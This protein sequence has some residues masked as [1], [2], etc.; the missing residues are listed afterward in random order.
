M[1]R[2]YILVMILFMFLI[3]C[4]DYKKGESHVNINKD[5]QTIFEN[6]HHLFNDVGKV[7]EEPEIFNVNFSFRPDKKWIDTISVQGERF[8]FLKNTNHAHE[9]TG[10]LIFDN[11]T[12]KDIPYTLIALQG[13][14]IANIKMKS[15]GWKS[16]IHVISK[17]D[18]TVEVPVSIQW[19]PNGAE[20]LTIFPMERTKSME[21]Q[22][23]DGFNLSLIRLF[24]QNDKSRTLDP[25]LVEKQ[26]F[27]IPANFQEKGLELYPIP[28][29]IDENHKPTKLI[30]KNNQFYI[31]NKVA[32]LHM[33]PI[34]Y[35]TRVSLIWI[36]EDGNTKL[37]AESIPINKEK[38][39]IVPFE[40]S[41]VESMNKNGKRQFIMIF[42]NRNREILADAIALQQK[43][44]M[45][46]TTWQ[47]VI[48]IYP[49]DK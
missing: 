12:K 1:L 39:T 30:P 13:N 16:S 28:S 25:K 21:Y 2:R 19:N 7:V 33:A 3:S 8:T 26:S 48:E 6:A 31:K 47:N 44:K 41:L 24:V 23:Y 14:S 17:S 46:L 32:G 11:A 18:A 34:P 49:E 43:K 40:K 4:S 5:D 35:D 45:G 22:R 42:S 36:D 37:V 27:Q 20:E 38:E 10:K 15:G 29:L 9:L